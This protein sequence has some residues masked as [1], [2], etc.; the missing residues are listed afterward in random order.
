MLELNP[1][2][3]EIHTDSY[4]GNLWIECRNCQ[5]LEGVFEWPWPYTV[6]GILAAIEEHFEETHSDD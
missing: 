3:F 6:A 1:E 2:D 4:D 5:Y